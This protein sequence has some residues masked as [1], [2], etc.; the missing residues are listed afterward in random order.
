MP[1]IQLDQNEWTNPDTIATI[2]YDSGAQ[3]YTVTFNSGQ[4]TVFPSGSIGA[5]ALKKFLGQ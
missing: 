2:S 5:K 1:F 4:F 3:S